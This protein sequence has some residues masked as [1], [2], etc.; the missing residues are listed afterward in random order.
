MAGDEFRGDVV[1]E[2]NGDTDILDRATDALRDEPVAPVP[3]TLIERTQFAVR[4][5]AARAE[6][7]RRAPSPF[8]HPLVRIAAAVVLA[9]CG[10]ATYLKL[11]PSRAPVETAGTGQR[12]P[13]DRNPAGVGPELVPPADAGAAP[14]AVAAAVRGRVR[15]A[16]PVPQVS[17]LSMADNAHCA[18]HH[19]GRV[20]DESVVVNPDGTL[21]N[22]VV[23]VSGGLEGK[24]YPPPEEPAVLDQRGCVYTPHV[25]TVMAG[26]RLLVKN[27]DP[28]LHNVR[29]AASANRSFNF[30]Q[31]TVSRRGTPLTFDAP[32]RLFVKCD[33]HPW[34]S[35]F[36]HVMDNPFFAVTG[37]RGAFRL[38][39]LPPG[40]YEVSAWHEVYGE[41]RQVVRVEPGKP[42]PDLQFTFQPTQGA[43]A[44]EGTGRNVGAPCCE[45]GKATAVAAGM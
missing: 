5:L 32:E 2:R 24:R 40:E 28:F 20:E 13:G 9:T 43:S 33:V 1:N 27:G 38:P 14:A 7:S 35:A 23:W 17:Y 42:M 18:A 44:G 12:Q 45:T 41:Q 26:Q 37:D 34:M 19:D 29:A 3:A 21:R 30:G 15:F 11:S 22:V 25:V 36:V 39:A 4:G 16:G 6:P 8:R 31:P 10:V